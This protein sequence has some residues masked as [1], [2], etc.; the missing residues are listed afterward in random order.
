MLKSKLISDVE[1]LAKVEIGEE[2]YE[3]SIYLSDLNDESDQVGHVDDHIVDLIEYHN[4]SL[5]DNKPNSF[6]F[7]YFNDYP[8]DQI[9]RIT[10][11]DDMLNENIHIK[12]VIIDDVDS[13]DKLLD[14]LDYGDEQFTFDIVHIKNF[15]FNKANEFFFNYENGLRKRDKLDDKYETR[16]KDL[17]NC[18]VLIIDKCD[19]IYN[20]I[21]WFNP[22]AL[23]CLSIGEI[24]YDCYTHNLMYYSYW[25]YSEINLD[26]LEVKCNA[27]KFITTYTIKSKNYSL[28]TLLPFD[29]SLD[30]EI[31]NPHYVDKVTNE[32]N[33]QL[34]KLIND[35]EFSNDDL[36]Q[37]YEN[38]L[39][40]VDTRAAEYLLYCFDPYG[41]F[42]DQEI[43]SVQINKMVIVRPDM[44]DKISR[45]ANSLISK[46]GNIVLTS[47]TVCELS[48]LQ[49]GT[50]CLVYLIEGKYI[51]EDTVSSGRPIVKGHLPDL[52]IYTLYN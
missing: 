3:E 26:Y 20:V 24:K 23:V 32:I 21:S 19:F 51:T 50:D 10:T 27:S 40:C 37:M 47:S 18:E 12:S 49:I 30:E 52:I 4:K 9:Y 42:P 46:V 38:N 31:S 44:Y 36:Y 45:V 17:I 13:L 43:Q 1:T 2:V 39:K 29:C 25:P 48:D 15:S 11:N 8:E 41:R 16:K 33:E 6:Y 34:P 28:E 22:Y 5:G 14:L 35:E 7:N